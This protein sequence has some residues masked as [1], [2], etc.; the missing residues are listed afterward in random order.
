VFAGDERV[1]MHELSPWLDRRVP[2]AAVKS[3]LLEAQTHR[4][5]VKTHLPLD[6]LVFS[7]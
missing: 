2:S 5:V 7:P 1:A 4:R 6:A 3:K